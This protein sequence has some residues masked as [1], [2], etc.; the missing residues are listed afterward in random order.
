M[1]VRDGD[2]GRE[3]EVL[4]EHDGRATGVDLFGAEGVPTW[5]VSA[6]ERG[7]VLR[8]DAKARTRPFRERIHRKSVSRLVATRLA[9]GR[10]AILTASDDREI[11]IHAVSPWEVVARLSAHAGWVEQA[12]PI[13]RAGALWGIATV[14]R[15]GLTVWEA[16]TGF[17]VGRVPGKAMADLAACWH[18]STGVY[19]SF[20]TQDAVVLWSKQGLN[21][22]PLPARGTVRASAIAIDPS[23]RLAVVAAVGDTVFQSD[24]RMG[25]VD[26]GV[27]FP[28]A[29]LRWLQWSNVTGALAVL[30]DGSLWDARW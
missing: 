3:L 15:V 16:E 30:E 25:F 12:V 8:W 2:G 22:I 27:R 29:V 6:D 10:D 13:S 19:V 20:T 18:P 7:N 1:V 26:A 21:S 5:I 11:L 9:D 28:A 23:G 4:E 24:G 17:A 14:D